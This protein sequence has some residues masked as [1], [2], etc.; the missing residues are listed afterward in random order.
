MKK[1]ILL[2]ACAAALASCTVTQKTAVT[3]PVTDVSVRQY[4]TVADLEVKP[5]K[6][7]RTETWPFVPFNWGQPSVKVRKGNMVAD[8][9]AENGADVL[10]EP[11]TVFTKR[12]LGPRKLTVTGYAATF[13]NFRK[14]TKED[15][16]ALD[17]AVP[18]HEK[19]VYN[20]AQPET[21][22]AMGETDSPETVKPASRKADWK[23]SVGWTANTARGGSGYEGDFG[24]K[25]GYMIDLEFRKPIKYGIF[26]GMQIGFEGRG[27]TYES[28]ENGYTED[29]TFTT[30]AF[31]AM[32]INFG[33]RY[34]LNKDFSVSAHIG[35]FV[36]AWM[37]TDFSGTTYSR[38]QRYYDEPGF[39]E[40]HEEYD[41]DCFDLGVAFGIGAQYKHWTLDF[42]IHRGCRERASDL[43]QRS[44]SLSLGY[45]F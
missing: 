45:V 14:A 42:D 11:Q 27:Y 31:K 29:Q 8:L 23:L 6:V 37:T 43:H 3:A 41:F 28:S 25:S 18:A 32:P 12:F 19:T 44:I 33:Y 17:M 5:Q 22:L 16:E 35:A 1:S 39:R 34:D 7:E 15:L 4:P 40:L 36:D 9:L 26:W 24:H 38:N 2:L 13:S 30:H 20:V 10:L 21:A